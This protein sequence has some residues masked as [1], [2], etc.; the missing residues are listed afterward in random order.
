LVLAHYMSLDLA[1]IQRSQFRI[2]LEGDK[3]IG[4]IRLKKK[5]SLLEIATLGVVKAYRKK[6]VGNLLLSYYADK[7]TNLHLLTCT[8]NYFLKQG[9]KIVVGVPDCLKSKFNNTALWA[10]YGDPVIL[11]I[12]PIK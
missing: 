6:G 2:A 5:K 10:G 11:V 9:F 8:P 7:Y 4:F 1:D 12:N 3:I